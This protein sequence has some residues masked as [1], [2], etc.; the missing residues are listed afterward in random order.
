MGAQ[1]ILWFG[2]SIVA[3]FS[4]LRLLYRRYIIKLPHAVQSRG[5]YT[6]FAVFMI[7]FAAGAFVVGFI[8]L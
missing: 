4:G 5:S 6:L 2:I 7:I 3:G 8:S 1:S